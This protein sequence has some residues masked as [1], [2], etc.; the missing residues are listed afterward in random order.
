MTNPMERQMLIEQRD[1][2]R[3]ITNTLSDLLNNRNTI[4]AADELAGLSGGWPYPPTRPLLRLFDTIVNAEWRRLQRR[5]SN[6]DVEIN[7]DVRRGRAPAVTATAVYKGSF[8]GGSSQSIPAGQSIAMMAESI[9]GSPAYAA[10]VVTANA[11]LLG[12]QCRQLPANFTLE[13]PRFWVPEWNRVP[14][15]SLPSVANVRAVNIMLPS[16][17]CPFSQTINNAAS[18]ILGNMVIV[19]DLV[20]TG[21]IAAQSRGTLTPNFNMR[22]YQAEIKRSIGPVEAGFS[23]DINGRTNGSLNFKVANASFGDLDFA[24]TVN[25]GSGTFDLSLGTKRFEGT[26]RG[27]TFRGSM[28]LT[29]KL[30]I[31]PV[32]PLPR[33]QPRTEPDWN[34]ITEVAAIGTVLLFLVGAASYVITAPVSVPLSGA[35]ALTATA[36]AMVIT[37]VGSTPRRQSI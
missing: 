33:T 34:R 7:V 18:I 10:E 29:A 5:Y 26:I 35:V 16:V 36:A 27:T 2:S 14:N 28:S 3:A 25:A 13:F 17:S 19:V 20:F 24:A 37:V 1:A 30:H 15:I 12:R 6:F 32:P 31:T 11:R 23:V 21:T 8:R 4:R 22:S 9:Y